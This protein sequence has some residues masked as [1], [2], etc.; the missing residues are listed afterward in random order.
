MTFT[1]TAE[2]NEAVRLF[3][4]G[5]DL[6]I[7]AG[8]GAAKTS[9]L[10]LCAEA[11]PIRRGQY[12][13]FNKAIVVEAGDK[14]P[15]T[16]TCS[17]AH[18]LAYRAVVTTDKRIAGRLRSGRQS[19]WQ[20][21]RTLRLEHFKITYGEQN[22]TVSADRLA[23]L[24]MRGIE[25]FCQSDDE[26][27][28]S[29]NLPYV[30]GIDLPTADGRR[31]FTN[32]DALKV[33]LTP[34][35]RM[36][37]VDLT[38]PGGKLPFKHSHYLKMWER[39]N[40]VILADYVLYD[41]AQDASPVMLSIIRQQTHAQKV[42][43]GDSAQAIYGFTGAV[44]A[45]HAIRAEGAASATLTQSFRFGDA[46]ADVANGLLARLGSDLRLSGFDQVV[47]VV[48]A[49]VDP[50]VILTRTN[51]E[52]V[53]IVLRT[54]EEGK[55]PALVGGGG[56]VVAFAEGALKLQNGDHTSHPELACFD[57]WA[58]VINYVQFDE[59]GSDLRLLVSLVDEFGADKIIAA[60][61]SASREADADLIVST[62][63]KS[64]GREWASVQLAGDFFTPE[65]GG[66]LCHDE[67]R[68][69]YVA[70]TRAKR[71]LDVMACPQALGIPTETPKAA[72]TP[73]EA[74]DETALDLTARYN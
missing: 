8:A 31:T 16:V 39:S 46:V 29:K 72:E 19:S 44:D 50:D 17:T 36:A 59:Q 49:V 38:N 21:A 71:E 40:P 58:A 63:H 42:F 47:S 68:L 61:G 33:Y 2:Q 27:P 69:L 66:D 32:N 4:T 51:A 13:A 25:N 34:F 15:S 1:P 30:D 43:V 22:K 7:E 62:A 70:C 5:Q 14:F 35:L 54:L 24:V 45:L 20:M 73:T 53:R 9:T 74:T 57:T 6:V 56:E 28:T 41:E 37:W 26:T 52:A 11:D 67:L 3:L 48:A 64:K 60:L 18:S 65:N 10:V 12:V 23:G 55:R